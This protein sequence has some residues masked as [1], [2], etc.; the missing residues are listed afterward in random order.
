MR[1]KYKKTAAF[2]HILLL[3]IPMIAFISVLE[4][5]FLPP[6][7]TISHM[8]CKSAA[9]TIINEAT[10]KNI[11]KLN[12]TELLIENED[13]Y[14]ANTMLV[15]TFCANLSK[16]ISDELK[17]LPP[18]S[19]R[20]PVG[21]VT[22]ISLLANAGPQIPFTLIPMGAAKV[23]YETDFSSAGIN[24]INYK[25]WLHISMEMKIVNPLYEE[26]LYLKRKIMLADLIYSGKIPEHYFQ[27]NR[28]NEY[29]L[30]E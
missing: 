24:Q 7:K 1:R 21:A 20:I 26:T 17:K 13:R 8:Q 22:K 2:L 6:L 9:N 28:P 3:L 23:D 11:K 12:T 27:F 5:R 18:E 10:L 14:T 30:T 4:F 25:I 15:N 19:I 16:D 29:L